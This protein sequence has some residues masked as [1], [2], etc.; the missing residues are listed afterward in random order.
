M[1]GRSR[2]P[3]MRRSGNESSSSSGVIESAM[4]ATVS[5]IH[6]GIDTTVGRVRSQLARVTSATGPTARGA[7]LG[8]P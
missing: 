6:D 3:T 7:L 5:A 2:F 4:C 1:I 8:C